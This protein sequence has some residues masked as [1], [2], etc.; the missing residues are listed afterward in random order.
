MR[1]LSLGEVEPL[2]WW[3]ETWSEEQSVLRGH[4]EMRKGMGGGGWGDLLPRHEGGGQT[5]GLAS[6]GCNQVA[7]D[8][9]AGSSLQQLSRRLVVRKLACG[10]SSYPG[11]QQAPSTQW[12]VVSGGEWLTLAICGHSPIS[13]TCP[14][15]RVL[16]P[17]VWGFEEGK[18]QYQSCSEPSLGR[19]EGCGNSGRRHEA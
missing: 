7:G 11:W 17:P 15:G 3:S 18:N 4:F 13:T 8:P 2:A 14:L 5:R 9:P 1:K 16:K 19:R 6:S 10:Q 12:Q